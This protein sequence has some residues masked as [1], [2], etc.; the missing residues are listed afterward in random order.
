MICLFIR[1][2]HYSREFSYSLDSHSAW[3]HQLVMHL[4]P[5]V[6]IAS[7]FNQDI[8]RM[9]WESRCKIVPPLG[10]CTLWTGKVVSSNHES[11]ENSPHTYTWKSFRFW[12]Q[13]RG[14]CFPSSLHWPWRTDLLSNSLTPSDTVHSPACCYRNVFWGRGEGARS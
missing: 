13:L 9:I 8:K 7:S 5:P 11:T 2:P 12:C 14:K 4:K 10:P 6:L 1:R 3:I